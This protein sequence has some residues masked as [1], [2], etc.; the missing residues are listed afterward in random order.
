MNKEAHTQSSLF[1]ARNL[2]MLVDF[3]ELTMANGFLE[4]GLGS[5]TVCFDLFFRKV[6]DGG[7]F[8]IA[9]GLDQ[10]IDYIQ[11]LRFAL[12]ING[13]RVQDGNTSDMIFSVD[14]LISYISQFFTLKT[15]DIL[16]TGTP[17]GVGPVNID[18]HLEG[19]LEGRKI[20]E[21]NCK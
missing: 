19:Y 4:N 15:G 8:A 2:T 6:P 9:A 11:N 7:G 20:L 18:D 3:Y 14:R 16:Y 21:F 10:I 1:A 13:N 5:V 12:D 17:V